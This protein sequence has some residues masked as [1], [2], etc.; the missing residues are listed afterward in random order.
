MERMYCSLVFF[1][2]I[3]SLFNFAVSLVAKTQTVGEVC[4]ERGLAKYFTRIFLRSCIR[5]HCRFFDSAFFKVSKVRVTHE[6]I[7]NRRGMSISVVDDFGVIFTER[8]IPPCR[9]FVIRESGFTIEELSESEET[10]LGEDPPLP[11]E[12]DGEY[13]YS[14][15]RSRHISRRWR[16]SDR[17]V[18]PRTRSSEISR[19]IHFSC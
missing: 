13:S 3:N 1:V 4:L 10:L 14:E 9:E 6:M 7:I 12:T 15:I 2:S 11:L 8:N 19:R 17:A 16:Q 18:N 5:K